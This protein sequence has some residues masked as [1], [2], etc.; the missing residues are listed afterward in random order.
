MEERPSGNPRKMTTLWEMGNQQETA[1]EKKGNFLRMRKIL[2]KRRGKMKIMMMEA[3][4]KA[5]QEG[6][7]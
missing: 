6:R 5:V 4:E 3:K 7:E 2:E 1:G